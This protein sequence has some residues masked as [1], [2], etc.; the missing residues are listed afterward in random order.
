MASIGH[1]YAQTGNTLNDLIKRSFDYYPK[2]KELD[3]AVRINEEK[4]LLAEAGRKPIVN[5]NAGYS[6]VAPVAEAQF[7]VAP[8]QFKTLQ[9]Q[10]HNNF[11]IGIDAMYSLYDFEKTKLN[12]DRAKLDIQQSKTNIEQ[13]RSMLAA[14]VANIYFSIIYL[15]D[16]I[17]I[18][19][20]VIAVLES[21]RQLVEN[22]YKN[23]DALKVDV[24]TMQNNIDIEQNRK[25][26][27]LR[28]L[29]SQQN[30]LQYTTGSNAADG[31]LEFNTVAASMESALQEAISNH[32]EFKL[33]NLMRKQAEAELAISKLNTRPDINLKGGTGFRNG[34]QPDIQEF[35][36]NYSIG[37]G[38]TVPI[39]SG[40]R[41]RQQQKI[42]SSNVELQ[43]ASLNSL[44]HQFEKDIK[45]A[46]EDIALYQ[47]KLS[48]AEEQINI[49][50]EALKLAQ[51]R[52]R[53]GVSTNVELLNAN[54]NLQ[55]VELSKVQYQYQKIMAQVELA[56][57]TGKNY[58]D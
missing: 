23:G 12:I 30:L 34:Y 43:Q 29:Q 24:L 37:V 3:Q 5:G 40:G 20:S 7:P 46:I 32:P 55:R 33:A 25:D 18:Q 17:N 39:Y 27:L 45:Q 31:Q 56:R 22:K 16:A 36:F 4:V 51:S 28:Q 11:N 8:G 42:A 58:W 35:R 2:F 41:L 9:F 47:K 38:V 13:S 44:Q 48:T 14:Q 57:L 49:A 21:N 52:Y 26:D 10:P 15:K 54:N 6:Y 19:D 1:G 53:N 50:K